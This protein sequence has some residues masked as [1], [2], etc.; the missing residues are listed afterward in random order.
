MRFSLPRTRWKGWRPSRKSAVRS[1][2]ENDAGA[3]DSGC[4][5]R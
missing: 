4:A 5:H 3:V 2:A 1:S